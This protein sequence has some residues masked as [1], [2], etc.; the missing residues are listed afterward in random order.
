M[1][2]IRLWIYR[3]CLDVWIDCWTNPA[4]L[5]QCQLDGN[6]IISKR[7]IVIIIIVITIL[8]TIIIIIIINNHSTN[9]Q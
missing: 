4:D 3:G 8:I 5:S 7:Y 9:L 1:S 6:P 2:G